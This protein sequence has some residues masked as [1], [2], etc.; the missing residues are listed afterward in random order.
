M[1][2][3]PTLS[4]LL[5]GAL[6]V[7]AQA[8]ETAIP[9]AL[10]AAGEKPALT[11]HAEGAQVYECKTD[12]DGKLAWGF[13]EPI[14]TLFEDGKTIGRHY[15]GPSWE[16]QDGSIVGGRVVGTAIGATDNDIPWLKLAVVSHRGGKGALSDITTVQRINTSGGKLEGACETAGQL[17]SVAY[18]A[19]YVFL[20]K[21]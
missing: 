18:A 6:T 19:D 10:I 11:L 7:Q 9:D 5:L 20:R 2:E 3:I 14:A 4:L 12:K 17:R 21:E 1:R 15:A 8:A 13:R 16:H